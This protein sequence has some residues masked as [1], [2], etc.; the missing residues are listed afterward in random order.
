MN[1]NGA[2]TIRFR[3]REENVIEVFRVRGRSYFALENLS[4]RGAYRVFDPHAGP[5]GDY[6][7]L[8][9]I[10][11]SKMTGQKIETLRRLTGASANR[12][13]P[14]IVDYNRVGDDLFVA[15]SWVWGTNLRDYLRGVREGKIPRPV[16]P[17]VI[18]LFRGLA[19]GISHYHRRANLI[20]G[21]I[22]PANIIL[23]SGT[24]QLV[25]VD[26]GSAW[27]VEHT[28]EKDA[29][30]GVTR[31]YAAPE[32]LAGNAAEDFRSDIFSLSVVAYE[33]LTLEIP[34][35]G[36]GG[37]I[38]LP[39]STDRVK[40]SYTPPSQLIDRKRLPRRVVQLADKYFQTGL[41]AHP[42]DRFPTREQWLSA[43]D[44]LFESTKKQSRLSKLESAAV[45]GIESLIR[46]ASWRKS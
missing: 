20:H 22:S 9:K 45:A 40:K 7:A 46:L 5:G 34:Y 13:F 43:V 8:H 36:L 12:N 10:P 18:R 3:G 39:E 19:H 16:A 28:A 31:P 30:D 25:L 32:R 29:G 21:D 1:R 44:E 41:S 42:N 23:T 6:R 15:T 17:E 33:F 26:F 27:P 4:R 24:K 38:G 14:H 35:D 37:Q 11:A 2:K